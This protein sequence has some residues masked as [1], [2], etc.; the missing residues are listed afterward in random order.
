MTTRQT[1]SGAVAKDAVRSRSAGLLHKL[2]TAVRPEFRADVL[3]ADTT[4]PMFGPGPCTVKGCDRAI[5]GHGLCTGHR[6]RW[7]KAGRPDVAVFAAETDPRWRRHQ[8]NAVCLVNGCGYGSARQGMC[9]LH[10]QRWERAR[11]P[12]LPGWLATAPPSNG[13]APRR[14]AASSTVTFGRRPAHRSATATTTRGAPM[15]DPISKR[16]SPASLR[17]RCCR[18]NASSSA[19]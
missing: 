16:S 2:M 5:A 4:D 1:A 9:A 8:P 6:Q 11:K 10:A 14:P 19:S 15:A 18:C 3:V 7:V 12:D 13:P 17:F